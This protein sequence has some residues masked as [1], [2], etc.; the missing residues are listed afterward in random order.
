MCVSAY[1]WIWIERCMDIGTHT[2]DCDGVGQKRVCVCLWMT[3]MWENGRVEERGGRHRSRIATI[4]RISP[5]WPMHMCRPVHAALESA[6]GFFTHCKRKK[7]AHGEGERERAVSILFMYR[8]AIASWGARGN[9][10]ERKSWT[11]KIHKNRGRKK[12]RMRITIHQR[13]GTGAWER[14]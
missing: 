14:E 12:R 3:R 1:A 9:T 7:Y 5:I 8:K 2:N 10:D 11:E 4:S 6:R 13:E